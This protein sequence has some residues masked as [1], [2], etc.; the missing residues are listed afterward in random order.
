MIEKFNFYDVYGY[1]IPGLALLTLLWVPFGVFEHVWP[2][3][4]LSSAVAALAFAY[5]AGNMLQNLAGQSIP[6]KQKDANGVQRYPSS[7][8]LD[9]QTIRSP[10]ISKHLLGDTV[11]EKLRIDVAIGDPGTDEH[12]RAQIDRR[13]RE[14]FLLSRAILLKEDLAKYTEQFEGMYSLMRGLAA[15]FFLGSTYLMGW[16]GS[17]FN[18]RCL[19]LL[20][21]GLAGI[22]ILASIAVTL[23][24]LSRRWKKDVVTLERM[25]SVGVMLTL[26]ALGY[27]AG[28]MH[29]SSGSQAALCLFTSLAACFAA[30]R[31]YGSYQYFAR[32]F[33]QAVWRDF[34]GHHTRTSN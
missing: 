17:F 27:F 21:G 19:H 30:L 12:I 22:G 1:F 14:A 34:V 5:I 6:S 32:E 25:V 28:I 11:K 18:N 4:Q 2:A 20:A 33:A 13:R 8:L 23:A 7:F 29:I 3:S 15:A 31:F 24:V 9:D 10:L 26:L 16:A